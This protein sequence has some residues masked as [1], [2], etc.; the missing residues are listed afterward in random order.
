MGQVRHGCATTTHAVRAAIQRSQAS[1]SELS[2]EFGI[3]PKVVIRTFLG[4]VAKRSRVIDG[5]S[6]DGEP[7]RSDIASLLKAWE[8]SNS[9]IAFF[10][11]PKVGV[12]VHSDADHV[13]V[14]VFELLKEFGAAIAVF[15]LRR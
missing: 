6:R 5:C 3:N 10:I 12:P 4:N 11:W 7:K 2:R 1:R 13:V 15:R 8:I 14:R 9:M